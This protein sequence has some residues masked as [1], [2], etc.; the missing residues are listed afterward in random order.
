VSGLLPSSLSTLRLGRGQV[1]HGDLSTMTEVLSAPVFAD[2]SSYYTSTLRRSS[3]SQ[4]AFLVGSSEAYATRQPSK[5]HHISTEYLER[6]SHSAPS[7]TPSSPYRTQTDLLPS[8]SFSSTPASSLSLDTKT[9]RDGEAEEDQIIFPSYDDVGYF[10]QAEDLD[11][12]SSPQTGDS[13]TFTPPSRNST[14]T[15]TTNASRPDTPEPTPLAEDDTAV[16]DEP[17]RHVDYLSHD[18]REEDIW[19]SWRH[20]V[21]KRKV[22]GNSARLENASWRTWA[23][24]KY[25]L[26]TVSPE[27]LNW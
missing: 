18:W 2:G 10:D 9:E 24:A 12:P 27:R 19:S 23:K 15:P 20:I 6:P 8:P 13:S 25:H 16:R 1:S 17:T 5:V 3:S 7:S 22:Y 14:S 11:A 21:S 26:K 4:S